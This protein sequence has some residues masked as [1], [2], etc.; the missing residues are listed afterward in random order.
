MQVEKLRHIRCTRP[1]EVTFTGM[2]LAALD[3]GHFVDCLTIYEHCKQNCKPDIGI[4]NAVL[5]V[6]GRSDM[7]LEAKELFEEIKRKSPGSGSYLKDF[8]SSLP[9]PDAYTFNLMLQASAS[10]EQW[11]Y[12]EYVYKEMTLVGYQFDQ[13][14]HASLLVKVSRAGKVK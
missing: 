10:A 5:K 6:Y 12:F 13:R 8:G 2:I 9:N 3:G 7:F 4:V 14:K 1:L 11:E